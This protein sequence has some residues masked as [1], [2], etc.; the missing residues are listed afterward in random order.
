MLILEKKPKSITAECYRTLRTNIQ[1][2]KFDGELRTILVTSPGPS[3]GKSSTACN[4]AMAYAQVG[5]RVLLIDC[6]LRKPSVHKR[7]KVFNKIGLSN[8]LVKDLNPDN[9]IIKYKDNLNVMTSGTIPPNPSEMLSSDKMVSFL[10]EM[11]K[12]YDLVVVDSPPLLP[13]TDAQI[14]STKVDGTVLVVAASQT[15]KDAA[16]KAK[17]LLNKVDANILGVVVSKIDERAG[18]NYTNQYYYYY[19]ESGKGKEKEENRKP[20]AR[21]PGGRR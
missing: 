6:D 3:E 19:G 5:K 1:F 8:C 4:L 16:L 20:S 12:Q 18:Y 17:D 11:E 2:S 15:T 21:R 9:V 7:F 10:R 14:L 13:V